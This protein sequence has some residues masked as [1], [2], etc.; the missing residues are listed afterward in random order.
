MKLEDQVIS[1]LLSK[2]LKE[3]GI[4]QN[5]L[6]YWIRAKKSENIDVFGLTYIT[7]IFCDKNKFKEIYSAFTVAELG[8]ILQEHPKLRMGYVEVIYYEYFSFNEF[9]NMYSVKAYNEAN[10][11]A[12]W[13][14]HLL[15][16]K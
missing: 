5:S 1:L 7:N 10:C 12:M 3:I 2:K 4:K 16:E 15:G 9:N 14:L 6:F 11:R 8:K 13:I